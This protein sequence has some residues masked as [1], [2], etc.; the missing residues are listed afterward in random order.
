MLGVGNLYDRAPQ[1]QIFTLKWFSDGG[2]AVNAGIRAAYIAVGFYNCDDTCVY[3]YGYRQRFF[4]N[5]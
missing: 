2:D 3:I 4:T 5:I 1:H